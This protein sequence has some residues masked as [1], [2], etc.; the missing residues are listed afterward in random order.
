MRHKRGEC[1]RSD[2]NFIDD[3]DVYRY[4]IRWRLKLEGETENILQRGDGEFVM[5]MMFITIFAGD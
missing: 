1:N 3:D 5:M 4:Y 2:R